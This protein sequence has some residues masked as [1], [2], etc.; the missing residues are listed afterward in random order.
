MS[1]YELIAGLEIHAQLMTRTKAFCRCPNRYGDAPNTL[2]CPVCLGTPGALP[3]LNREVVAQAAR[4]ATALGATINL[5]SRFDRKNYFYP[6]LPKGYQISQFDHPFALGGHL[7]VNVAG[8]EKRI[9]ITRAHIEEDAGKSM[10][11]PDGSTIVDM[12]RCGVP[13]VEIVSEPDFRSPAEA[14]AYLSAMRE[15]LRFIG[16]CDGN[17]DEGS[18]R[19]DANVS[20]RKHGEAGLRERCEMK[21]LNSFRNVERAI[22]AE[23]RRQIEIYEQGGEIHR[24]TLQWNE[25]EERLIP[26]R[27]K[28]G[29]DDYRYFPEPDLPELVVAESALADIRSKMPELPESRRLRYRNEY[30]LH[31]EAVYLLGGDRDLSDYFERLMQRGLQPATAAAWMQSEVQRI[32]NEQEWNITQFPVSSDR[33]ADLVGAVESKRINRATG[34]D[35][36]R[37]MLTDT[38]GVSDLIAESGAQQIQDT[39]HI[40][41]IISGILSAN[42]G[43]LAKYRAGKTNMVGFFMG[44]VMQATKGQADPQLAKDLLME[45]LAQ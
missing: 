21:N 8:V 37:T 3:V 1:D 30:A 10:H 23:M 27:V 13:L 28:E 39:D 12:N 19:C 41:Q 33:L 14:G 31:V 22:E 26:M 24:Q 18:L 11:L 7:V 38:R 9:N 42:P 5:R 45:L 15:L 43:E 32:L 20:V 2:V 29:S 17:M 34:R 6:D 16:V 36:L 40:R 44:Q 25:Q 35:L 4:L